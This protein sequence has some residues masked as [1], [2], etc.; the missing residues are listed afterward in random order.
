MASLIKESIWLGLA[1][2]F[3]WSVD[4][5][6]GREQTLMVLRAV[7]KILQTAIRAWAGPVWVFETLKPTPSDIAHQMSH[8][9]IIPIIL[10]H[11]FKHTGSWDTFIQATTRHIFKN[12]LSLSS[13]SEV[14]RALQ[15]PMLL[16][17][18]SIRPFLY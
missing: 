5:H 10:D 2:R 9:Q 8:I 15:S 13:L 14:L 4:D 12:L 7:T 11:T 3:K 17:E 18:W 16:V 6:H 1:Y